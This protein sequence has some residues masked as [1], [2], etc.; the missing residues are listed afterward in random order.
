MMM[1]ALLVG[2]FVLLLIGAE[3]MVRGAV[4]IAENLGVSKLVIGLTVVAL[5][6]SAPEVVVSLQA[7]LDGF[8]NLAVGNVVGSNIANVLLILGAAALI[9]PIR[10]EEGATHR[11]G[12][13]MLAVSFLVAGLML[14]GMIDRL[15][16]IGL[17]VLFVAYVGGTFWLEQRGKDSA[18]DLAENE[19]DEVEAIE[20]PAWKAWVAF[21]LGLAGILIGSDM[22]VTGGTDIA[23]AF[24]VSEEVIG[25]T[26]IAFGTSLPE[27][28]ASVVAAFRG[29]ADVA[30]GNV[31]GSNLFN[32]L[33]VI[34]VAATAVPL[35]VPAQ[36]AGFDIWVMLGASLI[37]APFILGKGRALGKLV[38]ICFLAIYGI[39]I[40]SQAIGVDT[41]LAMLGG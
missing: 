5:G 38:G 10:A 33:L 20:G 16:G 36:I 34:G 29:H 3:Y 24:G 41:F 11:D 17:L 30:L 28:A 35:P 32:L 1:Y 19:A 22:L 2:G 40:Y 23:R 12:L 8:P 27:L 14:T 31:V 26:L 39:Y 6:T 21:A 4:S 25:L 18:G 37:L 9:M 7:S 13:I 15:F